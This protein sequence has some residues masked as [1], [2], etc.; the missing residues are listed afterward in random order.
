LNGTGGATSDC[1]LYVRR[2][3][4]PTHT[5]YDWRDISLGSESFHEFD[6]PQ[7]GDWF[8]GVFGFTRCQFT[9]KAS[10]IGQCVAGCNGHGDCIN[11]A[12]FCYAGFSG[13]ACQNQ[14]Q[15]IEV[16]TDIQGTV[17]AR[18]WS[19]YRFRL[20][21]PAPL[22]RVLVTETVT[23]RS[24]DVD[25]YVR[26]DKAPTMFEW[27]YANATLQDSTVISITDARAGYWYIGV[28]GFQCPQGQDCRFTMRVET[29][30]TRSAC[31][32]EC[33]NRGVCRPDGSCQCSAGFTG[34]YCGEKTDPLPISISQPVPVRGL[35]DNEAWNY[36]FIRTSSMNPVVVSV[37]QTST[38][39]N[40]DCDLFVKKDT[41]P[42]RFEFDYQDIG[43]SASFNVTITQPGQAVWWI[44]VYGFSKCEYGI[45]VQSATLPNQCLNGGSRP[46]PTSPCQCVNGWSGESCEVPVA[47][48]GK[49]PPGPAGTGSVRRNEFK[50]FNY[51]LTSYASNIFISLKEENSGELW[52][53]A[54][55]AVAP[56]IRSH[57]YADVRTN[58]ATHTISIQRP[59]MAPIG[60]NYR[61]T[62]I[63]GVYGN[64]FMLRTSSSFQL[65]AWDF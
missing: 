28:Y 57:D 43:L 24:H 18:Q 55:D 26:Y 39:S 29:P 30:P 42:T 6:Q 35:V 22:V 20:A 12:C 2:G 52:L 37:T 9:L 38:H 45:S 48:L 15:T 65:V 3:G 13:D 11:G 64:P 34:N 14:E 36:Y 41:K 61:S 62:I 23:G 16:N 50:Y 53:F 49:F 17:S 32:N 1:D 46:F 10:L 58:S 4:L 31:P 59:L 5:R 25:V 54:S 51:T 21:T 47:Q 63:I 56:T 60:N 44:G 33:T 40:G 8:I 7:A 19:T 27:D